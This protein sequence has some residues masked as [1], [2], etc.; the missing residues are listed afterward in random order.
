[1]AGV[2]RLAADLAGV[3]GEMKTLLHGGW[4]SACPE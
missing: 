1:V 3:L 4:Q 2:T